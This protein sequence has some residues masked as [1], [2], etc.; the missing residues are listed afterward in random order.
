MDW[1]T[2]YISAITTKP[3]EVFRFMWEGADGYFEE[4]F[5]RGYSDTQAR[6][7]S[8]ID[9]VKN[10]GWVGNKVGGFQEALTFMSRA[11]DATAQIYGGY[12]YVMQQI[13]KYEKIMSPEE[14]KTK[15]FEDFVNIS[16]RTQ[17]SRLSSRLSDT[18][19]EG[20]FIRAALTTF[21][22]AISQFVRE[23]TNAVVQYRNGEISAAKLAEIEIMYNIVMPTLYVSLGTI[24]T[25]PLRAL[26]G[27]EMEEIINRWWDDLWGQ[28]IFGSAGVY[29]SA[30]NMLQ[31]AYN[32]TMGKPAYK[33]LR[34]PAF[35]DYERM[36][37]IYGKKDK[38]T[39]DY[40]HATGLLLEPI[41]ANPIGTVLRYKNYVNPKASKKKKKKGKKS[42]IKPFEF[43]KK[44]IS[45]GIKKIF[46][47]AA[48]V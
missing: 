23:S 8:D 35:A 2:G 1:V 28:I 19:L 3:K 45:G 36:I 39:E 38:S 37:D 29:P 26:G 10:L 11:G 31:Y 22:N 30:K 15:A 20:G 34:L 44:N 24:V 25:A 12:P 14:A 21:A 47:S 33:M 42:G 7:Q 18:Q 46:R 6:T 48:D 5:D 40:I 17:Q 32:K 27:E 9:A 43:F 13:A 41:A 4:R 16:S